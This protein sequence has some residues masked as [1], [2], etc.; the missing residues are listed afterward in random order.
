MIVLS[1]AEN[2]EV[3]PSEPPFLSH[4]L[5]RRLSL[6]GTSLCENCLR[7]PRPTTSS[8]FAAKRPFPLDDDECSFLSF[9]KREYLLA[10]LRQKDE[11]IDSLLK[12]VCLE[13]YLGKRER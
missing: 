10:Q 8:P 9:S 3:R 11:L 1:R 7:Y 4:L 6:W 12:Q 13:H 2:R 5:Q